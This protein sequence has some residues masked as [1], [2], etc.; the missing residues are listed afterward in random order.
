M[1]DRQTLARL[2]QNN[3]QAIFAFEQVLSDVGFTLPSTIE[4]ANALAGQALAV[5]HG[6]LTS[7]AVVEDVLAQLEGAPAEQAQVDPDDT[8]PSVHLGTMC[9][10]NADA[11]EITGG[12][13]GLDAGTVSSPSLYFGGDRTTGVYRSALD[14]IAVAIAGVKL[15]E[16][17]GTAL[18]VTGDV[19][20]SNQL[21][22]TVATGTAPLVVSSQTLV[23]NLYVA[24]AALADNATDADHADVADNADTADLLTNPTSYP[25][26]ATD[27]ATAITLVNAL[28]AAAI[29]KGL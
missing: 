23:D 2:L 11:V 28:K 5:A 13:I 25:P 22:S 8:T 29:S 14:A 10:Q 7:L 26:D 19:S 15:V 9:S 18:A 27:L 20:A 6:A 16:F 24:R 4:E 21:K 1:L 3:K 17:A 12:T